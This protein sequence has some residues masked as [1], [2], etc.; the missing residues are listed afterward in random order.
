MR[1]PDVLFAGIILLVLLFVLGRYVGQSEVPVGYVS[2]VVNPYYGIG[3]GE[4]DP[5]I[6]PEPDTPQ[7]YRL[8]YCKGK[9]RAD[10]DLAEDR[11]YWADSG[12]LRLNGFRFIPYS[13]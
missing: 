9:P 8:Y 1:L 2:C 7:D 4:S 10:V 5:C 13:P 12:P 3:N 6:A 11:C